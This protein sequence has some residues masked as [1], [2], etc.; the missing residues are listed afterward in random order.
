MK[1]RKKP[2][3]K[4]NPSEQKKAR[5][6]K[7]FVSSDDERP[8]WHVGTIDTEG[9]WGWKN[10]DCETVWNHIH[11]KIANFET[12]T[13]AEIKQS[14]SHNVSV[15]SICPEAKERL[16]YIEMDDI[17]EL[18][19]LRLTGTQRIWGI[20]DRYILKILWW[21]PKHQ[22]YPSCLRYT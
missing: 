3:R 11:C 8:T 12:M 2:S 16:K 10:L 6:P 1:R 13:W 4:V 20:R 19:S 21:D 7:S 18:F 22:V 17:D 5:S 9:P 15:S 14:G